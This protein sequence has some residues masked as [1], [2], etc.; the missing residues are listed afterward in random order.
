VRSRLASEESESMSWLPVCG[1]SLR[2]FDENNYKEP[3]NVQHWTG[4]LLQESW[5]PPSVGAAAT[6]MA[7]VAAVRRASLEN[8][9]K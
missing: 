8:I 1:E 5:I 2:K 7:I 9:M 3:V 4:P 6:K